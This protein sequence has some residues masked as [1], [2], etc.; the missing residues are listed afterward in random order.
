MFEYVA[1]TNLDETELLQM[2]AFERQCNA[3]MYYNECGNLDFPCFHMMLDER[4]QIISYLGIYGI[5]KESAEICG[6][7][8]PKFRKKGLFHRLITEAFRLFTAAGTTNVY[9]SFHPKLSYMDFSYCYS[10]YLLKKRRTLAPQPCVMTMCV[11]EFDRSAPEELDV[12]YVIYFMDIPAGMFRISGSTRFA[13]IHNVRI[14]K[15]FRGQGYG[16]TLIRC[17]LELFFH[18]YK[19]DAYLNVNSKNTAAVKLYKSCGF[20]VKEEISY[21][22]CLVTD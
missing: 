14:R 12:C 15:S 21:Y 19:C 18:R 20:G 4:G 2:E 17:G 16:A 10:E 9:S 8:L 1:K 11:R 6:A 22:R 13:C 5:D 7:T 3:T